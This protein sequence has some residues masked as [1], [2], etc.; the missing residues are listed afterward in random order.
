MKDTNSC[1]LILDVRT[2]THQ[3]FGSLLDVKK[4]YSLRLSS[5]SDNRLIDPLLCLLIRLKMGIAFDRVKSELLFTWLL[6]I[7][8]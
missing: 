6:F 5:V 7:R 8:F 1:F 4:R 3:D 2:E